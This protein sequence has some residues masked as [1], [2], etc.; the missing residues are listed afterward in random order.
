MHLFKEI[1]TKF[2]T[3]M[4][5][6]EDELS[7]LKINDQKMVILNFLLLKTLIHKIQEVSPR[8]IKKIMICNIK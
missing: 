4:V 5:L 7:K 2:K 8:V 6:R 1:L 3:K